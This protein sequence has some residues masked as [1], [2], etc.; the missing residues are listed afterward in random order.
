MYGGVDHGDH[1]ALGAR[2]E[3]ALDYP[4]FGV[5]DADD[6]RDAAGGDGVV[7]L[8]RRGRKTGL[9]GR[10]RVAQVGNGKEREDDPYRSET[11]RNH[12]QRT[13]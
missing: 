5:G 12:C 11:T 10:R 2:V 3:R 13:S 9:G 7:E 4:A 1:Q 8:S 6:G